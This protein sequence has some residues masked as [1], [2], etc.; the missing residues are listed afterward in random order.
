MKKNSNHPSERLERDNIEKQNNFIE[1][2]SIEKA[3]SRNEIKS[4][5][6]SEYYSSKDK[7]IEL[8]DQA[9]DLIV[10]NEWL[11]PEIWKNLKEPEAKRV[12][13]ER[14]GEKL[15]KIF[16]NPKPP[17]FVYEKS[18]K[19]ELG[20]YKPEEWKI[21]MFAGE[22]TKFGDKLFGDDPR[23]ALR[24]YCHEFRH[25]YQEE[26]ILAYKK[27]FSTD[28]NREKLEL[29][30]DN[31]KHYIEAP[32]DKLAE[33][34]YERY[35]RDYEKYKNQPIEK[36]ADEFADLMTKRVYYRFSNE[37]EFAKW[38]EKEKFAKF[39]NDKNSK[40]YF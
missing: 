17:L 29:W 5:N 23:A 1:A 38:D 16:K 37:E 15:S 40:E 4:L 35:Q 11:N 39:N 32:D 25:S 12:A 3:I 21:R 26:Q 6:N 30:A 19:G 14:T 31:W 7:N 33:I 24:T 18:K 22:K 36:D 10:K 28:E 20:H 8:I 34:D 9:S 13:L 2:K 27:G